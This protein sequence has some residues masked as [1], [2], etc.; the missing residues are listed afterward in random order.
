MYCLIL[1]VFLF[2]SCSSHRM[3][4]SSKLKPSEL[5]RNKHYIVP[6]DASIRASIVSVDEKGN[7]TYLSEVSPD[8]MVTAVT[9][10]TSTLTGKLPNS[11]EVDASQIV[12]ITQSVTELGKRTV[13]VSILR[14]ALYRLEEYN[15]NDEVRAELRDTLSSTYKLFLK[16]LE[17]A[18]TIAKAELKAEQ[19]KEAEEQTKKQE[20]ENEGQK[21]K[22]EES[23]IQLSS[24]GTK[25]ETASKLETEGFDFLLK[26]DIDRAIQSFKDAET[27]YPSFHNTYE[28]GR[29]LKSK[30]DD[31]NSKNTKIEVLEKIIKDY[32]WGMPSSVLKELTTKVQTL[33]K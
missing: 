11:V 17:V 26:D 3:T 28:I 18:E 14:D 33:K 24:T 15:M 25:Y 22:I 2:A 7:V 10:L 20:A 13:A 8:A 31:F 12:Q 16:T 27:V 4:R 5:E 30:K 29:L 19:V 21:L 32:S 6:T 23:K 1:S 9:N